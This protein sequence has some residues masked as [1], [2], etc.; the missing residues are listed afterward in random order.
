MVMVMMVMV[1]ADLRFV[2][3]GGTSGPVKFLGNNSN[4]LGNYRVIY[5][6]N[7]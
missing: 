4:S 6:L 1:M 5:E 2:G 7:E 3:T